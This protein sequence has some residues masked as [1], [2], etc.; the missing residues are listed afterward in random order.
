MKEDILEQMTYDWLVSQPGIFAKLNIKFKPTADILGY[1]NSKHS[2]PSDI[3]ILA[4]NL[5]DPAA[6]ILSVTCKSW[7]S[8]FNADYFSQN[9]IS[10]RDKEIGGKPIWKHFRELV[11]N[12]WNLAFIKSIKNEVGEF[13][14]LHYI[15]AITK[16]EGQS[17][18]QHFVN[19]DSFLKIFKENGIDVTFQI[20]TVKEMADSI[21]N[22]TNNTLE[23]TDFARL[24]QV[25]KA[26]GVI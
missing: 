15:L 14:K 1:N 13:Q 10:N 3:D 9:L 16:F 4:K 2:V 24:I 5:I 22:R 21:L 26:G 19:N 20:L 6:P 23:P 12:I 25:L 11:D 18:A 7:Q 8:G 17:N